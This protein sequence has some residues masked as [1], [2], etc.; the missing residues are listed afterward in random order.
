M[1]STLLDGP[2]VR[3]LVEAK[4]D[5]VHLCP[6]GCHTRVPVCG[7]VCFGDVVDLV[8]YLEGCHLVIDQTRKPHNVLGALGDL[9]DLGPLGGTHG[10]ELDV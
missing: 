4:D 2:F 8:R 7:R 9:I 10:G 5:V 6:F 3:V 1:T